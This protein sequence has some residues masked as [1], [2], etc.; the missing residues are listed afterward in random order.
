MGKDEFNGGGG[1]GRGGG[2]RM[3]V[4]IGVLGDFLDSWS[5]AAQR[6]SLI[7]STA[8]CNWDEPYCSASRLVCSV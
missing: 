4:G 2:A 6:S 7:R 8:P 5:R 1:A 3:E